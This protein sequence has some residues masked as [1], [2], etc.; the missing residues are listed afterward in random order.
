M[1]LEIITDKEPDPLH[2]EE[3]WLMAEG[4][5]GQIPTCQSS[6]NQKYGLIKLEDLL[7]SEDLMEHHPPAEIIISANGELILD[8]P[9]KALVVSP[10]SGRLRIVNPKATD[11]GRVLPSGLV[12]SPRLAKGLKFELGIS[13]QEYEERVLRA[14][15]SPPPV[16]ANDFSLP[17]VNPQTSPETVMVVAFKP[18]IHS[19]GA[20]DLIVMAQGPNNRTQLLPRYKIN[21][22]TRSRALREHND[23]I[24]NG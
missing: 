4:I 20:Q 5:K 6:E 22:L 18:V 8:Y 1:K 15:E 3:W 21:P 23:L 19:G 12:Y 11:E 10:R 7:W 9:S 24:R 17:V 14:L 16:H 13:P 2:K